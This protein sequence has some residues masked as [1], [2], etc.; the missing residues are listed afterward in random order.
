MAGK[1]E[2]RSFPRV[3]INVKLF[4]D[5]EDVEEQSEGL[6]YIYTTDISA[7]GC[8]V[9]ADILFEEGTRFKLEFAL[10]AEGK[11]TS[12]KV[13]GEVRWQ[14]AF[15]GKD[16]GFMPSGMGIRFVDPDESTQK[17]IDKYLIANAEKY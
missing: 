17:E 5:N 7:G 6:L 4:I 1:D 13:I 9:T 3:P 2:K 15:V 12:I 14:Q 8:F 10:P 16:K 11:T